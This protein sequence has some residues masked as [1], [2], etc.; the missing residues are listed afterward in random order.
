LILVFGF[1]LIPVIISCRWVGKKTGRSNP[2]RRSLTL[3]TLDDE[4]KTVDK[5]SL[6]HLVF[7]LSVQQSA[8]C[9]T[10]YSDRK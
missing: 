7:L 2:A 4:I 10:P 1:N 8:V 9:V 5:G 6:I 3:E